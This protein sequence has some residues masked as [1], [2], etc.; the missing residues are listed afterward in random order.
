MPVNIFHVTSCLEASDI[1]M[2]LCAYGL[3]S[4]RDDVVSLSRHILAAVSI[5]HA[6][7]Y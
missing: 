5:V 4:G 2:M 3:A 7:N 1:V 6:L